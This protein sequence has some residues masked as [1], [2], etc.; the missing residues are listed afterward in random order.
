MTRRTIITILIAI[1]AALL[2]GALWLWF[3]AGRGTTETPSGSFGEGGNRTPSGQTTTPNTNIPGNVG[4]PTSSGSATNITLNSP[5]LT[6]SSPGPSGTVV[7]PEVNWLSGTDGGSPTPVTFTPSAINQLNNGQVGGSVNVLGSFKPPSGE[8][9]DGSIAAGLIAGTAVACSA[10]LVGGISG[11]TSSASLVSVQVNDSTDNT[12]KFMDCLARTIARAALAQMTNSVV[13]WINSGFNGKPA[14]ITNYQ[15]FFTNVADQAAGEFIR[16]YTNFAPYCTPF[17]SQ[18]QIA[19][20]QAYARRNTA[21]ACTLSRLLGTNINSFMNGNFNAGGWQGLLSFTSSPNNNPF[22]AYLGAQI[23][24]QNSLS[25]AQ[26]NANRSISPG[27]FLSYAEA[28]NCKNPGDNGVVN[29]SQAYVTAPRTGQCP[30]NCSCR[31]ATP[32]STIESSLS[33][34]LGVSQDTLTLAGVSGSFDAIISA[35]IQQLITRALYQGVSGLSGQDGYSSNYLTPN[36]QAAQKQ[37][38]EL[39]TELQGRVALAQQ[40]GSTMQGSIQDIQTAQSGLNELANCWLRIASSTELTEA[41]QHTGYLFYQDSLQRL[42]SY[43]ERVASFNA[44]IT[45]ANSAIATLQDLQT[46]TLSINSTKDVDALRAELSAAEASGIL[47]SQADVTGAQQDRTTLQAE[48][49]TLQQSTQAGLEQC[50]GY[51]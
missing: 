16:N 10:F 31:I 18:I 34:Q 17:R 1:I 51:N 50:N 12:K 28:Y 11:I 20:A 36:Q 44:Q 9:N 21:Q 14:F 4:R 41:K 6:S 13:N 24:L 22:G 26:T 43:D 19:L 8:T 2:I 7:T 25:Q 45:R 40:Y 37:G 3:F 48:M 39:L 35:L 38:Q 46:R 27:G 29:T 30:A 32:G 33:K 47:I 49:N 42:H 5:A 23:N 15:Q